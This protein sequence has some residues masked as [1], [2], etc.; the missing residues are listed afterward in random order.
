MGEQPE[1][2]Q[3]DRSMP[4]DPSSTPSSADTH[5]SNQMYKPTP[6]L[7]AEIPSSAIDTNIDHIPCGKSKH[8]YPSKNRANARNMHFARRDE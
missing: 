6:F 1:A 5:N 4:F 2:W 8:C 3:D 7:A